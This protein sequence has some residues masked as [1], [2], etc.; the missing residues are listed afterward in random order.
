[1]RFVADVAN[2]AVTTVLVILF[3]MRRWGAEGLAWSKL[4]GICL[5]RAV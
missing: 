4:A 3:A 2:F 1:M 5:V